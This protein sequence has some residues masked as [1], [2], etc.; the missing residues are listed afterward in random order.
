GML[1]QEREIAIDEAI[2]IALQNNKEIRGYELKADEQKALTGTA[3]ALDK[4]TIYY[5]TDQNNIADNNH[6]LQVVGITQNFSFPTLYNS[7]KKAKRI[8]QDI[9][10]TELQMQRE[11]LIVQLSMNYIE[12]QVL[13]EQLNIYEDIDSLYMNILKGATLSNRTGS[14]SNLDLLNISAKQ[15]Q[16]SLRLK[17]VRYNIDNTYKQLKNLMGY[18][19][20]FVVSPEIR[21]IDLTNR[22]INSTPYYQLLRNREALSAA[23]IGVEK[24]RLLPDI[25]FDYFLGTNF[26]D[27]SRY[28]HG[29]EAG[30]S[31]PIFA[32]A[33]RAKIKAAR[34]A[35]DATHYFS[36]YEI[37]LLEIKQVNLLNSHMRL[38]EQL[39][40]FN[41][42]GSQLYDEIF[43]A[44]GLSFEN[45]EIDF[46]RYATSIETALQ[47]KLDYLN[48]LL[49]YSRVTL[50][51]NYLR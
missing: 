47:I 23:N 36:E 50:E 51:L 10:I 16:I 30:L 2:A 19:S 14:M 24:K 34:L 45:G 43:R 6:P 20:S 17:G 3:V 49:E 33:Q 39:D 11:E 35:M 40:Y 44:A 37:Q 28:Y 46:F 1:A 48:N 25:S 38:K 12:L 27:Q 42:T 9:S 8:E 26:F 4:T 31:I 7:L 5:G 41:N 32:G 21:V 22:L 13:R 29:F 15:Q 18:D